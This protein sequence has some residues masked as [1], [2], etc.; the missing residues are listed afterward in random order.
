MY[1]AG[2]FGSTLSR[3]AEMV[4][5]VSGSGRK[6]AGAQWS[7]SG[8]VSARVRSHTHPRPQPHTLPPPRPGVPSRPMCVLCECVRVACV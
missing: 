6:F 7:A 8:I 3:G 4:V 1:R 2:K 5:L